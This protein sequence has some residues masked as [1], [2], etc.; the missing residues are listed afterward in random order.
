MSPAEVAE[1]AANPYA[2]D[3]LAVRRWDD[4]GKDPEASAPDFAHF[5]PLLASL[6]RTV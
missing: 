2:A 1:H 6:L 3:G 5:R 4:E